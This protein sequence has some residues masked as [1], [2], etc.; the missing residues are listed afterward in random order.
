MSKFEQTVQAEL[1]LRPFLPADS[2]QETIF[3]RR[4]LGPRQMSTV[5]LQEGEVL[6]LVDG[7]LKSLALPEIDSV[8]HIQSFA[9]NLWVITHNRKNTN[10]Q[11]ALYDV[12]GALF[13][14]DS[15]TVTTN[16][17]LVRLAEP[18]MGRAILIFAAPTLG[19]EFKPNE[20]V[21]VPEV[22]EPG[23]AIGDT[24]LP[25]VALRENG[26]MLIGLGNHGN[27][28]ESFRNNHISLDLGARMRNSAEKIVPEMN[29]FVFEL[30]DDQ[31]WNIAHN[32]ALLDTTGG[33]VIT[34]YYDVSMTALN[35]GTNESL[36]FELTRVDNRYALVAP[37]LG[38][39][40]TD[41]AF[42]SDL[43]VYQDMQSLTFL[44]PMFPLSTKNGAGGFLGNYKVTL[45]ATPKEGLLLDT[46]VHEVIFQVTAVGE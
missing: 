45:T 12:D 4:G 29:T 37:S 46:V 42:T 2:P 3:V 30:E 31:S 34:N 25:T 43:S 17:V 9:N 15:I 7:Q 35:T 33:S 8:T 24:S 14:P 16:Q 44:A 21:A 6:G 28:F 20:G 5:T 26:T 19:F 22:I 38:V 23:A 36:T 1:P 39:A 18:D 40:V 11:V 27:H 32:I 13:E 41:G 10:V